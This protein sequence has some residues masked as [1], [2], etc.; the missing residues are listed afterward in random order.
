MPGK[1]E[2]KPGSP[3]CPVGPPGALMPERGFKGLP[4]VIDAARSA[5][6][7]FCASVC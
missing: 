5:E 2:S 7:G 6:S 3:D 1:L 4:P